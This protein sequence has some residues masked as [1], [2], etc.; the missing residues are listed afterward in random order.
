M[1]IGK[2]EAGGGSGLPSAGNEAT[3]SGN[4]AGGHPSGRGTRSG[5]EETRLQ[6]H[7]LLAK[8]GKRVL[9]PGGMELTRRILAFAAP[10]GED[11]IVE[12]GP[13]VGKTAELLLAVRPAGYWGV[14]VHEDPDNPLRK[15]LTGHQNAILVSADAKET[16]LDDECA[17]MVVGE[18]MLTMQSDDDKLAI[19]HEA[20]R[21][22]EPGGRYVLHEMGFTPDAS[23][24]VAREVERALSR[25]IK[26]GARPLKSQAW[27]ALL[28]EAGFDVKYS[29]TNKMALL[30][31]RRVLSDEGLPGFLRFVFN[32]ARNPAA[33]R[34]VRAMRKVFKANQHHVC[35]VG[36]VAV[37]QA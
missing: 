19:M 5:P 30:D 16:G 24:D 22:L 26:V 25:T 2:S 18:A 3:P 20:F 28:E 35:A 9:R 10:R 27:K 14:D 6:G 13:G 8:M 29:T 23:P 31:V 7:W 33:R 1:S 36:F 17:T 4:D 34:R 12:F 32:V 15:I 11:R 37:K 21:L